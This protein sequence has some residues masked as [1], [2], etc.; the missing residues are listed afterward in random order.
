MRVR[1]INKFSKNF[2]KVGFADVAAW[3]RDD[4]WIPVTIGGHL[5]SIAKRDLAEA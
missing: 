4:F 2:E 5:H 1:V 3:D